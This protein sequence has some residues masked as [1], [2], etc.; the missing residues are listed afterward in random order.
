[1]KN[2]SDLPI[3]D[4]ALLSDCHSAALVSS[5]G[6][7]DWLCFPRWRFD[8]QF[9][10]NP[11]RDRFRVGIDG[12]DDRILIGSR[13]LQRVELAL[14]QEGSRHEMPLPLCHATPYELCIA[15]EVDEPHVRPSN[16]NN[17]AVA[18]LQCRARDDSM[19]AAR[20]V[21]SIQE[22]IACDHGP[23]SSSV[24]ATPLCIF[25]ERLVEEGRAIFRFDTYGSEAFFGDALQLHKAIAGQTNGRAGPGVSPRTALAV[26]L[27]WMQ[28]RCLIN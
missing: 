14:K 3:A 6:S 15:L 1:M 28:T 27:K 16:E 5:G 18:P 11:R 17:V 22:A 13:L 23:R 19:P 7:V 8:P 25:W 21:A 2:T 24:S 12:D 9:R 20:R 4:Y 26:G 10:D